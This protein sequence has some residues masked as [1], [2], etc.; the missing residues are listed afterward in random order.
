MRLIAFFFTCVGVTDFRVQLQTRQYVPWGKKQSKLT[1]VKLK[2]AE[3]PKPALKK[4]EKVCNIDIF[5]LFHFLFIFFHQL[6]IE[7]YYLEI[8]FQSEK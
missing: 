6:L 1:E 5:G 8:I 4:V 2:E 3:K 7:V